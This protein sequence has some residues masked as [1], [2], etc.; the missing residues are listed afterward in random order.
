VFQIAKKTA[1]MIAAALTAALAGL[2]LL[3]VL[4][5]SVD[6]TKLAEVQCGAYVAA[7]VATLAFAAREKPI[8]PRLR[9]V[10][11][12][13]AA[14]LGMIGALQPLQ[15]LAPGLLT[16][17]LQ[18]LVGAASFGALTLVFDTAALRSDLFGW[19]RRRK[20][21]AAKENEPAPE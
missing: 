14:T 10:A 1:P 16:L 5:W 13:I 19:I 17:I 20:K 4:P 3:A 11:G 2:T 8:W 6:A 18:I 7:F 15:A 12:A 9:D 21:A